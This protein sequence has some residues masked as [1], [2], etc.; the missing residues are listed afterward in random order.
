VGKDRYEALVKDGFVKR[1][2]KYRF[3]VYET[4]LDLPSQYATPFVEE[5][6]KMVGMKYPNPWW[7]GLSYLLAPFIRDVVRKIYC[8]AAALRALKK[9]E[10]YDGRNDARFKSKPSPGVLYFVAETLAK[11]PDL[12]KLGE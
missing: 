12:R 1:P 10:L 9:A 5:L 6:E 2:W 3:G 4:V 8:S 7:L 11:R